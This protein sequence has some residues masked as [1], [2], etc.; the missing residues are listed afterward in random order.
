MA[1]SSGTP[2]RAW[3]WNGLVAHD[4]ERAVGREQSEVLLDALAVQVS[5]E[6]DES[7]AVV[8]I[9]TLRVLDEIDRCGREHRAE[10]NGRHLQIREQLRQPQIQVGERAGEE[11]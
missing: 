7:A 8:L 11:S 2:W 1:L 5:H 3:R 9:A 6:F 4:H 10:K